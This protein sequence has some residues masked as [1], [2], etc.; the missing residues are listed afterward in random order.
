[1]KLRALLLIGMTLACLVA[2]GAQTTFKVEVDL[3][4]VPFTVTDKKGAPVLG[5]NAEDFNVQ[6]DGRPENILLFSKDA[7]LPLALTML[8][9]VSPS[10]QSIFQKEKKA[11]V[12]FLK[13]VLRPEDVANVISFA[14]HPIAV[15]DFTNDLTLLEPK[16]MALKLAED[17]ALFDA[18]YEASK[19]I[20][21]EEKRR[22]VIVL[23]S[24]GADN[25]KS[26]TRLKDAIAQANSGE[27]IIY[28]VYTGQEA[29]LTRALETRSGGAF[30]LQRFA[31]E[32]GGKVLSDGQ[33]FERAFAEVAELLRARYSI[34][35][36]SSNRAKDGK[37]RKIKITSRVPDVRVEAKSGYYAEK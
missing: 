32:T 31:E 8:I 5:L 33:I 26:R 13:T 17:T 18:V 6:E 10:V 12:Q 1:M 19:E 25:G 37:F 11:S 34:G 30:N 35:Y 21:A 7:D 23:V 2:A 4:N 9:D 24:D 16:I 3:V 36:V 20:A 14:G 27:T 22:H 15:Q 29:L 28:S